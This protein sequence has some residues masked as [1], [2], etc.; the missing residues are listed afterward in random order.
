VFESYRISTG[1][2]GACDEE[3]RINCGVLLRGGIHRAAIIC[4][5]DMAGAR[6]EAVAVFR[7]LLRTRRQ[8]FA[9][10]PDMLAASAKQIREEFEANRNVGPG[11]ELDSLISKGRE[12]VEF[13]RVNIV[14]AKLNERGNYGESLSH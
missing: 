7:S 1:A 3:R 12:G 6:S 2:V 13:M 4:V 5:I 9:G 10:D 8:C 14:Q 11:E